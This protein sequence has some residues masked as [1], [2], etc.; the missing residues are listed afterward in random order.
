MGE[1]RPGLSGWMH[2]NAEVLEL[3]TFCKPEQQAAHRFC[4]WRPLFQKTPKR[5]KTD[6]DKMPP[7]QAVPQSE[8]AD[9]TSPLD[10]FCK[11]LLS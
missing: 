11:V 10:H 4:I 8:E 3:L 2:K 7:S 9:Y 1:L 6:F 5:F